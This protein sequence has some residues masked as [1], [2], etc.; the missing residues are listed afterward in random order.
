MWWCITLL[1]GDIHVKTSIIQK[2]ED[3]VAVMEEVEE[4]KRRMN[5]V[6]RKKQNRIQRHYFLFYF[7]RESLVGMWVREDGTYEKQEIGFGTGTGFGEERPNQECT[8]RYD[9]VPPCL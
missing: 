3:P 4:E 1:G 8:A 5:S 2:E 7:L 9:V 6:K